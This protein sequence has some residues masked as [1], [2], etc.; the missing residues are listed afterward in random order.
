MARWVGFGPS[1]R[2]GFRFTW[3]LSCSQSSHAHHTTIIP[4]CSLTRFLPPYLPP[5]CTQ[6]CCR[7]LDAVFIG[8]ARDP[9]APTSSHLR[10][11]AL[12]LAV[13]AKDMVG[14]VWL[15][16]VGCGMGGR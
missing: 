7:G 4:T 15:W 10:A 2:V 6:V 12:V 9:A 1:G 16:R 3:V 8:S 14:W 5:W 11:L 13:L